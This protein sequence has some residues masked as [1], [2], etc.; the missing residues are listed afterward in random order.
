MRYL[1]DYYN[2]DEREISNVQKR[3]MKPVPHPAFTD[4]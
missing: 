1:R 4:F 2:S 3:S